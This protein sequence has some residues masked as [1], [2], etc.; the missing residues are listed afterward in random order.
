MDKGGFVE[1]NIEGNAV[2][3]KKGARDTFRGWMKPAQRDCLMSSR[4]PN[5]STIARKRLSR[6]L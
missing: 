3:V 1:I 4:T 2:L 5:Q 6:S